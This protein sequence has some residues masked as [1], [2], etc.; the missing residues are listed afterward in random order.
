LNV[1][2]GKEES[3]GLIASSDQIET[4]GTDRGSQA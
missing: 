2:S 3:E 4:S 1:Q